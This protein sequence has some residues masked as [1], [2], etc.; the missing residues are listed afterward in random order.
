MHKSHHLF[1]YLSQRSMILKAIKKRSP[2][3]TLPFRQILNTHIL[4]QLQ[5]SHLIKF[6]EILI[7]MRI[8]ILLM[9]Y[10]ILKSKLDKFVVYFKT[11]LDFAV[12]MMWKWLMKYLNSRNQ[13]RLRQFSFY[14]WLQTIKMESKWHSLHLLFL[15]LLV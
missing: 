1:F 8:V 13:M 6:R 5:Y 7:H 2:E 10:F 9:D 4:S 15:L 3:Y 12:V 11:F 14:W